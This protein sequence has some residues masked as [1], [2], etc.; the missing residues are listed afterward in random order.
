MKRADSYPLLEHGDFIVGQSIGLGDHWN[1]VDLVVQSAHNF[2]VEGLQRVAGG[3]DEVDTGVDTVVDDVC[4]VDF[5]L[6]LE[7]GIVSL[8][9]ILHN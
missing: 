5:V 2:N 8:L 3:L 6:S 4:T 7:V 9:N 1:Q